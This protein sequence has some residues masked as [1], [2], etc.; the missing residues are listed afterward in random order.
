MYTDYLKEQMVTYAVLCLEKEL[1][2]IDKKIKS[3]FFKHHEKQLYDKQGKLIGNLKDLNPYQQCQWF[4]R[5]VQV[6][7]SRG[8]LFPKSENYLFSDWVNLSSDKKDLNAMKEEFNK[9][10]NVKH[11]GEHLDGTWYDVSNIHTKE[12]LYNC[13]AYAVCYDDVLIEHIIAAMKK[14]YERSCLA[15]ISQMPWLTKYKE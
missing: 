12:R 2:R 6:F 5:A 9:W 14:Y 8:I 13:F 4:K 1:T 15:D 10:M 3:F 7:F 11:G